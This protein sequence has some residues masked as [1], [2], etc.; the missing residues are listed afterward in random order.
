TGASGNAGEFGHIIIENN[1]RK[2][3][4]GNH[5]CWETMAS[6]DYIINRFQQ[7]TGIEINNIK[8]ITRFLGNN[9]YKELTQIIQ[10]TA[11]HIG[12]GLVNIINSLSPELLIIGG[13]IIL[14]KD[15]IK[16]KIK[17]IIK[18]RALEISYNQLDLKF[19]KLNDLAVVYGLASK[20]FDKSISLIKQ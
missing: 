3:H 16:E 8:E 11:S 6:T 14:F 1:G 15:Y 5:G 9:E 17:E 18:K 20:V 2:C 10:D 13:D 12:L 19:S 4:C 7:S